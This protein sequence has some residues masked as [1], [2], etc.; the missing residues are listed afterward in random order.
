MTTRSLGHGW[1]L[2]EKRVRCDWCHE[3]VQTF[4][5]LVDAGRALARCTVCDAYV[6]QQILHSAGTAAAVGAAYL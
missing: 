1:W 6:W 2:S 3:W 4:L 5:P